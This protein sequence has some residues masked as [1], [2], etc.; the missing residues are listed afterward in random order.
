[1]SVDGLTSRMPCFYGH[2]VLRIG[3]FAIGDLGIGVLGIKIFGIGVFANGNFVDGVLIV[4][5]QRR[6]WKIES[7]L[8]G[9]HERFKQQ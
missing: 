2:G 1:M 4:G 3:D 6:Y 8:N 9:A 7:P 5:L